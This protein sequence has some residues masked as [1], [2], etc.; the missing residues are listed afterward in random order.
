MKRVFSVTLRDPNY[1][2]DA[3]TYGTVIAETAEDA[4][5]RAKAR[6]KREYSTHRYRL[7]DELRHL[8]KAL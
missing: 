8:G 3:V 6:S 2:S 5:K 1:R 4:I 7:V